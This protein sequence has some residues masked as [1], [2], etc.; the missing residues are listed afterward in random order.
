MKKEIKL[1]DAHQQYADTIKAAHR[2]DNL[3]ALRTVVEDLAHCYGWKYKEIVELLEF[4]IPDRG[5]IEELL[6]RIS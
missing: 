1:F 3:G 4:S 5:E 6:G 2:D